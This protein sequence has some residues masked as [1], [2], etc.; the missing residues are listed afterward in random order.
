MNAHT[1]DTSHLPTGDTMT[2]ELMPDKIMSDEM[3]AALADLPNIDA[4]HWRPLEIDRLVGPDAPRHA[5]RILVLYGS[6]RE[7]SF[8]RFAAF[9]ASRRARV[10]CRAS[11]LVCA[12]L[13]PPRTGPLPRKAPLCRRVELRV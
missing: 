9:F 1:S 10:L 4:E 2:N 13:I 6:L 5:P 11:P 7:R 8:S 12:P 3:K